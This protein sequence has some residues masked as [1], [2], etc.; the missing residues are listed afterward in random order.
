MAG[1]AIEDPQGHLWF[2]STLGVMRYDPARDRTPPAPPAVVVDAAFSSVQGAIRPGSRLGTAVGTITFKLAVPTFRDEDRIRFRHRLLPVEHEWSE[3]E[4]S[5]VVRLASVAPGSYRFEAIAEDVSGRRSATVMELPFSVLLPWWRTPLAE[6]FGCLLLL[7]LVVLAFRVRTRRL[8]RE[9]NR[10][11]Q[12]VEERTRELQAQAAELQRLASTDE[13]TGTANRRKFAQALE[14]ELQRLSR[15]PDGARLSL[16]LLDLDGFKE[17]NDTHG[18]DAG[19]RLLAAIGR[20]LRERLRSTDLVARFGGDEFAVILPLTSRN[21]AQRAA[22]KLIQ[23][24]AKVKV[25]MDDRE[26]GVTASA[27]FAVVAST[28]DV[29]G[30]LDQLITQADMALYAAKRAGGN[31]VYS[32]DGTWQ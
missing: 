26:I 11:E 7:G 19:D 5:N 17:I 14:L 21:G 30:K 29:T 15:S 24:V 28:A 16:I 32:L 18:H 12:V 1:A 23:A 25:P 4:Y 6:L 8:Q 27:G 2:A 9:R 13:L 10:L 22:L 20:R 3:P 31:R